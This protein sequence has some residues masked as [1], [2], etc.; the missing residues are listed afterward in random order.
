MSHLDF[1]VKLYF[2]EYINDVVIPDTTKR[3]NSAMNLSDYFCVIG[4]RLIMA[5]YVGHSSRDLFLKDPTTPQKVAPYC[6]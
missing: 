1:F 4:C 5:C 2:M 3:L 6:S